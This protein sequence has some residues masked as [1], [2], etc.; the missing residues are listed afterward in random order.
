MKQDKKKIKQERERYPHSGSSLGRESL[1]I[2]AILAF[3]ITRSRDQD[4][5]GQRGETP[6]LLKT[7]KLA[8]HGGARL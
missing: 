7:Q 2:P 6:S 3:E 5:P 1:L 8:G 4:H